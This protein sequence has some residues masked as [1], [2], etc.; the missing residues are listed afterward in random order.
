MA[1]ARTAQ[2]QILSSA[3]KRPTLRQA[4]IGGLA[5]QLQSNEAGLN[6]GTLLGEIEPIIQWRSQFVARLR[7]KP[8]IDVEAEVLRL[9]E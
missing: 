2:F 1:V 4:M 7:P 6:P 9:E 8:V 5:R 3:L